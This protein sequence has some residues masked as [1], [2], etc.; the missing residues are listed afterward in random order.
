[1]LTFLVGEEWKAMRA[2]LSPSF[3][4]GKLRGVV[5]TLDSTGL[6]FTEYLKKKIANNGG[7]FEMREIFGKYGMGAIAKVI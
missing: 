3:T 5:T 1:M 2:A 6:E 7:I 4:T